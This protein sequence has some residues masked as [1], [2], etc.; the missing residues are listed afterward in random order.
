MT[1]ILQKIGQKLG[2]KE[3]CQ[4]HLDLVNKKSEADAKAN[5]ILEDTPYGLLD[6]SIA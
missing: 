6:K 4:R 5:E 1:N 3:N 2:G